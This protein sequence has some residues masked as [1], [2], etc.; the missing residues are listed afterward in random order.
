MNNSDSMRCPLAFRSK[1]A[2]AKLQSPNRRNAC[3]C[4]MLLPCCMN[5][6]TC[7]RPD[8]S[9]V[10]R[11]SNH[12]RS[13]VPVF[14]RP[15]RARGKFGNS[16]NSRNG[17]FGKFGKHQESHIQPSLQAIAP[18][19]ISPTIAW[20]ARSLRRTGSHTNLVARASTASSSSTHGRV[21]G[22][23]FFPKW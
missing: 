22:A 9:V 19:L 8:F 23:P 6:S 5:A 13:P 1:I 14:P 21:G 7:S 3:N 15:Y 10:I 17:K 4:V 12:L 16:G 18:P 20:R 2:P 11:T